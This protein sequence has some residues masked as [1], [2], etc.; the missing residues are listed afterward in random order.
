MMAKTAIRSALAL[1][2]LF[3]VGCGGGEDKPQLFERLDPKETGVDFVNHLPEDPTLNIL[4]Y[5]NYYNGG[6]VAVGD[7]DG[8]GRQ[9][10]YFTA[11]VGPN[12]LYLNRGGFAFEDVTEEAGVAGS[13]DWKTGVSMADVNA[14]GLLDIY[15]AVVSGYRGL[16]GKNQLYINNGDG[17][18]TEQAAQYGLDFVGLSVHAAFFDYD[19]D[20]DL[21]AYLLNHSDHA[22]NTFGPAA[23]L[24]H[25]RHA[26]AGDRLL[27]NE[28]GHFVDVSEEAGIYGGVVGYGLSVTVSDLNA[29]GCPDIYVGNDFHENDYL[30]YNNCDGTFK[31]SVREAMAHNSTSS[32]GSDVGDINNDGRPDI[33]VADMLPEEEGVLKT[34]AL[35]D[36][37]EIQAA[38]VRAG[39]HHQYSRNVLQLNRG[40]GRFSDIAMLAG[41]EATDWSW[42]PLFAD[43]DN[44][45]HLDLFV[46]NGI[47]H[48]PIDLD[49]IEKLSRAN[50][51]AS[52][53]DGPT[54]AHLPLIDEM[55]QG[56]LPNYAFQNQGDLTF[57]NR[58]E[59]WGLADPGFS[60][61]AAYADLDD[62]GDLDL[63]VNNVNA[64]ASIYRN[65]VAE[66]T[67]NHHLTVSLKG[68]GGNT[69][70]VGARVALT[71]GRRTLY[72]ERVPTR[73]FLSS[74]DPRLH[75]GLGSA[76]EID[77]L[78]VTWGDG[79]V[80]TLSDVP[81]D[82]TLTLRQEDAHHNGGHPSPRSS[83]PL[84]FD[85]SAEASAGFKHEELPF[86][87]WQ[88]EP[89]IPQRLST[90][91]PA[92]TT[93]DVNRD[94]LDDVFVGGAREQ[95]AT[96]LLQTAEGR[97]QASGEA[98][99]QADSLYEDVDAALF[100]ADADGD[101][102]LYVVSAGN[103]WEGEAEVLRDRLY[104]NDGSG[105]YTRGELPPM[106]MNGS[107]VRPSD[108]DGDGDAD[109]FVG[110]RVVSGAY[111]TMPR[112]YLL[113]NEGGRF[114]DA[115][116]D[117]LRY[118][119]MITDAAWADFDGDGRVDLAVVGD[120]MRPIVF[121]NRAGNWV[122]QRI[123]EKGWWSAIE[124]ADLNG[125]EAVDLVLGNHGLNS[126]LE[127]T[128]EEP[129]RLY[130]GDFDANGETDH[131]LTSYRNGVSYPFAGR[132]ELLEALPSLAWKFPTYRSYGS[133]QIED[134][135]TE[136]A[137][138]QAHVLE[139]REMASMMAL[140]HRGGSFDL[141][142]LPL[143]AQLAPVR[144]IVVDDF[145]GDGHADIFMGGNFFGVTP[146]RGRY[147]ASYG[148]FLKGD[149]DGTFVSVEPAESG[150][151]LEGEIRDL[152]QLR[153]PRG[154]G[155]VVAARNDDSLQFIRVRPSRR[156][157]ALD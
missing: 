32:M 14:D 65:N 73:G 33:V 146:A 38:K 28:G 103:E 153:G 35:E 81:A 94:G 96:L 128:T 98:A 66:R 67:T 132:D 126:R 143:E 47:Y 134:V 95:A 68:A 97:F 40:R 149:G 142:L 18:F 7:V 48:R 105:D 27:R 147:D 50:I 19:L 99:F 119:G 151:W 64:P 112:S 23:D 58:A 22:F 93:G 116:P 122:P 49:I 104:L 77:S 129:V 41:V 60:N 15:V 21:D 43:L 31:E 111:G 53:L 69:G 125:D 30:Y 82:T 144:A 106:H 110:G 135:L 16:T 133:S 127:A 2:S 108:F 13:G 71:Q 17:T 148:N 156:V 131:L 113:R 79:R 26:L 76:S 20:G 42:A 4:N 39:Y 56:P 61:G 121:F 90:E 9:D 114:V 6:G 45:G 155:I 57:T 75:F 140:N 139:A 123:G 54:V 138:R 37:P 5:L 102:D 120:W 150:L 80:Q 36:R 51:Q 59:A 124:A 70:G 141:A 136:E 3:L 44:D 63:V 55:P 100:D 91:G 152:E 107:V 11:N 86:Q 118:P 84:F 52:L 34:T 72:R 157:N 62:D 89:L 88:R 117:S 46:T 92:L 145:D 101:V 8:D 12:K 10:L 85:A 25:T 115:T 24:R 83:G 78:T 154:V 137:L 109:L 1:T 130:M 87:D 29:N 74:V